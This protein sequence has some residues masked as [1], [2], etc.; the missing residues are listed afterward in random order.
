MATVDIFGTS[1]TEV[2]AQVIPTYIAQINKSI[3][4]LENDLLVTQKQLQA[5]KAAL[6]A[7][8]AI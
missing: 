8:E 2:P 6:K 3:L 5:A 1:R 4:E 7:L